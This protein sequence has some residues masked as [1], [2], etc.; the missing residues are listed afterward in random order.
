MAEIRKRLGFVELRKHFDDIAAADLLKAKFLRYHNTRRNF[1]GELPEDYL[2]S[3]DETRR[4]LQRSSAG[5]E[6]LAWLLES[7]IETVRLLGYIPRP[8]DVLLVDVLGMGDETLS[9]CLS[10]NELLR[11]EIRKRQIFQ[12]EPADAG[13]AKANEDDD[14]NR[15]KMR[16]DMLLLMISDKKRFLECQRK[17]IEL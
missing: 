7:I 11:D 3:L 15:I 5:L 13:G 6:Y 1:A 10:L 14:N 2:R 16:K 4:E 12:T 8:D 17:I 9:H